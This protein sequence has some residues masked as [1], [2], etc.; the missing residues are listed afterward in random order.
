MKGMGTTAGL[1]VNDQLVAY[2]TKF[3]AV[4]LKDYVWSHHRASKANIQCDLS[5]NYSP[6][7][8]NIFRL[9]NLYEFKHI[10]TTRQQI[11]T[12]HHFSFI[13]VCSIR[14]L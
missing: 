10:T 2:A 5:S 7:H 4:R 6:D 11:I 3:L 1:K 12:L 8:T 13:G 14:H 9:L